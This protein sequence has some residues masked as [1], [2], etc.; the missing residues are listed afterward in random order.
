MAGWTWSLIL[1]LTIL[2]L[3]KYLQC[4]VVAWLPFNFVRMSPSL[5]FWILAFFSTFGLH[6]QSASIS[7]SAE[8]LAPTGGTVVLRAVATYAEETGAVGWSIKVPGGWSLVSLDGPNVPEIVPE[9]GAS[10]ELEFAFTRIP[11]GR[12][13][14]SVSLRYPPECSS[15]EASS[16]ALI[17]TSG[18]LAVVTPAPLQFRGAGEKDHRRTRN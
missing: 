18:K 16:F 2:Y 1:T 10:G 3:A 9:V 15:S 14:F 7:A 8:H 6:A 5:K 4:I 13:E 12:A 17:R 11:N